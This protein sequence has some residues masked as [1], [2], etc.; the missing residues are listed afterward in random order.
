M[1]SKLL[2]GAG[3]NSGDPILK[4][5]GFD[6]IIAPSSMD[7]ADVNDVGID[8]ASG[9]PV[10]NSVLASLHPAE[11]VIEKGTNG[12]YNDTSKQY[13]IG[14]TTGLAAGD[15][16]YLSHASLTDGVYE[17]ATVVDGTDITIVSNPLDGSGNQTSISYQVC[18]AYAGVSGTAPS[19]S[20]ATN[21]YKSD[22]DDGTSNTQTEDDNYI[23]D[24]PAGASYIAIDGL[25]Y[26]GQTTADSSPT[27]A[28]LSGWTNNGGV[29]H[30]ELSGTGAF[31]NAGL[32]DQT[33]KT[34][35]AAESG[36]LFLSSGDGAKSFNLILRSASGGVNLTVA[37]DITLD[38][39]GPTIV[40]SLVGR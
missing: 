17:I 29:T 35:A 38:T 6:F 9:F 36:G 4:G 33:E 13:T 3:V 10:T 31:W 40:H 14:S 23:A 30:V 18:W 26:T 39:T 15:F 16:I 2:N 19:V 28:I 32:T 5:L 24:A 22:L 1:A 8:T 11:T 37:C 12:S 20:N 21:Y 25:S 27:L 7:V 34:L